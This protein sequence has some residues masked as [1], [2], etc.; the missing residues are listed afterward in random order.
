MESIIEALDGR[1]F[2]IEG[3]ACHVEVYGVWDEGGR[4]WVQLALDGERPRM[5]TLRLSAPQER[6]CALVSVAS[7]PAGVPVLILPQ[8][9]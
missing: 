2:E 9:R 8:T 4:R 7:V 3:A 6:E 5:L 1:E